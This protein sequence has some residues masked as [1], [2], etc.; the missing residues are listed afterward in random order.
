MGKIIAAI[1]AIKAIFDV[2]MSVAAMIIQWAKERAKKERRDKLDEA[3][4]EIKR[5]GKTPEEAA[6]A[7]C[8]VE[9]IFDPSSTCD[10]VHGKPKV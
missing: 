7:A 8:K 4:N 10:V 2:V 5:P 6:A 9:K 1:T 3:I